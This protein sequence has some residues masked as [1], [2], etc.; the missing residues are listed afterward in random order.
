MTYQISDEL[1]AQIK[2]YKR[3][4]KTAIVERQALSVLGS[5]VIRVFRKK[6]KEQIRDALLDINVEQFARCKDQHSF[7][8]LF[9]SAL[10]R[11]DTAI[12]VKNKR[13]SKVGKGHKWGHAGK[14]T[15]LF[16]RGLVLHSRYFDDKTAERVARF[17]YVPVDRVVLDKLRKCKVKVAPKGIKDIDSQ[18]EFFAIQKVIDQAAQ[19]VN[20]PRI[21]F[22]DAWSER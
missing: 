19:K 13:N 8:R 18:K 9:L 10:S 2:E 12:L 11:V 6:S 21:L 3:R 7:D 16:L 14:I 17:L 20:C 15:N 4:E 1:V 22:D 5:S